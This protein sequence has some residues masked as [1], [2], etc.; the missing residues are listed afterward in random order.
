M[1]FAA[2]DQARGPYPKELIDHLLLVWAVEYID[3]APSQFSMPGVK[4]DV[5]VVDLVDLSENSGTAYMSAWWRPGR[6]IGAL[7]RRLHHPDP[8]LAWMGM[9]VGKPGAFAPYML[10][11]A[12]ADAKAVAA[13]EAWISANPEWAP[14]TA[15]PPMGRGFSNPQPQPQVETE[16]SRVRSSLERYANQAAQGAARLPRPPESQGPVPF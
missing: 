14:N 3:D 12:T 1:P 9:G 5:I 4:S 6:L 13:A 16:A 2:P 11:D 15:P 10:I 7:K 8:V